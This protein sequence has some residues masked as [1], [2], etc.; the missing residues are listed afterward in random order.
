MVPIAKRLIRLRREAEIPNIF[1]VIEAFR[2]SHIL[3]P[4]AERNLIFLAPGNTGADLRARIWAPGGLNASP[5]CSGRP[6]TDTLHA[7][8]VS[9]AK[10]LSC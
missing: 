5:L 3:R 4:R 7:V 6:V 8:D 10:P 9:A 2:I 1:Y